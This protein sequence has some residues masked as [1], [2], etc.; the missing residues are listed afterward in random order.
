MWNLD[1]KSMANAIG[2]SHRTWQR[3]EYA[4]TRIT[5]D[6]LFK[7][8]K[9]FQV[10]PGYFVESYVPLNTSWV[11]SKCNYCG[12]RLL[13]DV[14]KNL[15]PKIMPL[16]ETW[17]PVLETGFRDPRFRNSPL[18][19]VSLETFYLKPAAQK[20]LN[21]PLAQYSLGEI[22]QDKPM[23]ALLF[24][25]LLSDAPGKR[26]A[27]CAFKPTFAAAGKRTFVQLMRLEKRSWDSPRFVSAIID[28][29]ELESEL[30]TLDLA[31]GHSEFQDS[32]QLTIIL[33]PP[34]D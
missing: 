30:L 22:F 26:Y 1:Q 6:I 34:I 20:L 28:A 8:A 14:S 4:D 33:H 19:E 32:R 11:C 18:C 17:L 5:V 12:S 3:I 13:T 15:H 29:G 21:L 27:I 23:I 25:R 7:L 24:E 2:V 9:V 10:S 31:C 16:L